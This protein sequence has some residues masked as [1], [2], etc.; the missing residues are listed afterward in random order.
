METEP[1]FK[2]QIPS[3]WEKIFS[4]LKAHWKWIAF[5]LSCILFLYVVYFIFCFKTAPTYSGAD[6]S[7][8]NVRVILFRV[9]CGALDVAIFIWGMWLYAKG[10]LNAGYACLLLALMAMTTAMCYSFSTPIWD[11]GRHWNQHDD[12]YA[13]TGGQYLMQDGILDGG[14]GHFGLIMTVFRT[15]RVPEIIFQNGA[16]DF[17]FSAVGERYQPKTFYMLTGF[18]MKINSL[19]VHGA[20]GN[21][22]ISSYV[23]SNTEWTLFE[24]NRILW[25]GFVWFTYYY[26]YKA[27]TALGLKGKALPLAYACIVFCP[28][29]FFFCELG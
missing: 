15:G 8:W 20:E 18:F 7:Y 14:S 28:M 26:I 6:Q 24:M 13:S 9:F 10:R 12:Y 21:V 4:Y 19:V 16:Y 25:T 2:R 22:S 5:A 17:S 29:F 11:Y 1:L 3:F 23:M 27:L